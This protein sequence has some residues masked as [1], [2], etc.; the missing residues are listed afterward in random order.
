[1]VED[2]QE[3]V[4]KYESSTKLI[5]VTNKFKLRNVEGKDKEKC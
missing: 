1:M 5:K 3:L 4:H 2:Q